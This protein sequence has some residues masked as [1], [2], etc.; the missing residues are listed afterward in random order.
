MQKST[1]HILISVGEASGDMHAA[2]LVQMVKKIAPNTKF[3]GMGANLMRDAG[4]DIIVDAS[5]LSI[6]GG[7]EIILKFSK[8]R[9]AFRIMQDALLHNKPDLLILVDYPG[10]NLRLAKFAKKA[11][12]KVLYFISPKIWAWNQGRVEIIKKY[13]DMMAVIFPFE[14]AFYKKFGV[15]ATFVGNPLLKMVKPKLTRDTAK[16]AFCLDP[17]CKT[18][19]LFPG[20]RKSEINYLLPIMLAAAKLLKNQN[21][22]LQFLLPQANSITLEDLQPHLQSGSVEVRIIKDQN[23]DVIQV[24]DAIIAASGTATLEIAI[25]AIPQ[26]IIYKKSWLEY[27]IA[28]HLI[29]IPYIGLCN[30]LANKKIVQE[31]LQYDATPKNIAKEIEKILNDANYR[32]EMVANLIQTKKSLESD[33]QENIAELIL[34]TV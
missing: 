15:P 11:G 27:Q 18:I 28:R 19:G 29:K 4:I 1:K 13:V 25:M 22:N 9:Q 17:S 7:L 5:E 16:Q 21:P 3:Y 12:V 6:V 23:Y 34:E 14:V 31:F 8:I 24:C 32:E 10:F 26:V 33:K 20:S 30:I 2:N